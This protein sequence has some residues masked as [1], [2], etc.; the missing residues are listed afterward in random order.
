MTIWIFTPA[1]KKKVLKSLLSFI[2][3]LFRIIDFLWPKRADI[4]V[5]GSN[6]G[7]SIAGS[8]KFLYEYMKEQNPSHHVFFYCP[9]HEED[10]VKQIRYIIGFAPIFFRAKFLISSHPPYDFI[11]FSWSREKY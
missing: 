9:F 1:T 3:F 5:F 6:L 11:P 8:P 10:L 4:V 7:N 2:G